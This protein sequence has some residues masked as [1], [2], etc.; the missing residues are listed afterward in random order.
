M[1]T[2]DQN[3]Q[4]VP[5]RA[6]AARPETRRARPVGLSLLATLVIGAALAIGLTGCG[7]SESRVKVYPVSGTVTFNGEPAE[8]AQVILHP[9]GHALPENLAPLGT[10]KADGSF[11][12]GVYE[13]NDGAP[14]GDYVA[15]VE[16]LKVVQTEG[17]AGRGPN[18][19]PAEYAKADTSPVKLTVKQETNDLPIEI[20]G[21]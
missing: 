20:V 11:Q 10:V 9:Q 6:V 5:G 21:K 1:W 16:W 2:A 14:A 18:V 17:G 19:L 7:K 8:G 15:T 12:I 4:P 3:Q 13:N